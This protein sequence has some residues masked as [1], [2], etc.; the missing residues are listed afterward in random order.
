MDGKKAV[1]RRLALIAVSGSVAGLSAPGFNQWYLAWCCLAPLFFVI[2]QTGKWWSAFGYSWLFG[3]TFHLVWMSWM[4]KINVPPWVGIRDPGTLLAV[5][6]LCWLLGSVIYGLPYAFAGLA[7]RVVHVLSGKSKA[8]PIVSVLLES[9][10]FT[11]AMIFMADKPDLLLLPI[12]ALE[13]SQY[14]NGGVLQLAALFGGTGIQFLLS[15]SNMVIARLYEARLIYSRDPSDSD[16]AAERGKVFKSAFKL[17]AAFVVLVIVVQ[18]YGSFALSAKLKSPDV[19]VSILQCGFMLDVMS[20]GKGIPADE[21]LRRMEPMFR[22]CP[23]GLVVCTETSFPM[24][25]DRNSELLAQ[26]RRIA[27]ERKIDIV[28]G[29]EEDA[30]EPGKRYNAAAGITA[31]GEFSENTYRKQYLIPCG[32]FQPWLFRVIPE[33]TR[34]QLKLPDVPPY[35]AGDTA[36]TLQLSGGNAAPLICG[37]NVEASLC[38]RSIKHNGNVITNISNLSWFQKSILGDQTIAMSAMRAVENGRYY[39]YAADTGPSFILDP[40]GNLLSKFDWC[41]RGVLTGRISY[42]SN[43]TMFNLLCP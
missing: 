22:E 3:I 31:T 21:V 40:H 43:L 12:T 14:N 36:E 18:V 34:K 24:S 28:F 16:S 1:L 15:L 33:Q 13:Y 35:I 37:E 20:T 7:L 5:G 8:P 10:A 19:N 30:T 26:L 42:L 32:E 11:L 25:F 29:I 39:V 27:K 2:K 41:R 23:P 6:V 38:A 17:G 4:L 9:A